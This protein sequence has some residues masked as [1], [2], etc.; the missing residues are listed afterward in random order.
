MPSFFRTAHDVRIFFLD[1][2]ESAEDQKQRKRLDT[3]FRQCVRRSGT[4]GNFF[5]HRRCASLNGKPFLI[6]E[7]QGPVDRGIFQEGITRFGETLS[8][9]FHCPRTGYLVLEIRKNISPANAIKFSRGIRRLIA[10]LTGMMTSGG[11]DRVIIQTPAETARQARSQAEAHQEE[12]K[13]DRAAAERIM[14]ASPPPD[15]ARTES[16]Q[17]HATGAVRQRWLGQVVDFH[18]EELHLHELEAQRL[19]ALEPVDALDE[20]DEV[21]LALHRRLAGVQRDDEVHALLGELEG[22]ALHTSLSAALSESEAPLEVARHWLD[23][24]QRANAIRREALQLAIDRT[25]QLHEQIH[26]ER[27]RMEKTRGK[28]IADQAEA[29]R[30][31]IRQAQQSLNEARQ[32]DTDSVEGAEQHL[33]S[34][35]AELTLI[36]RLQRADGS[37]RWIENSL[38]RMADAG[39]TDVESFA[40]QVKLDFTL[41]QSVSQLK[42]DVQ[43]LTRRGAGDLLD[44]L[45]HQ[46]PGIAWARPMLDPL[47]QG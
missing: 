7:P 1:E 2:A 30:E 46:R 37:M 38:R 35:Q 25:R 20:E 40:R 33:A 13:R 3:V 6:L 22:T 43:V 32:S 21:L 42:Q 27:L 31:R 8:G 24:Q 41:R 16:I 15:L 28:I 26:Q 39:K 23:E 29:V 5:F 14:E 36:S 17:Q 19:E 4:R 9:T 11:D 45:W 47:L 12:A 10:R 18:D 34:A 44:A